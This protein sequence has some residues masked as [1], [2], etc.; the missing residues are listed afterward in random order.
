M[1]P[2]VSADTPFISL[3]SL[4]QACRRSMS[5]LTS[6]CDTQTKRRRRRRRRVAVTMVRLCGTQVGPRC[7]S[8][9]A[10]DESLFVLSVPYEAPRERCLNLTSTY[11]LRQLAHAFGGVGPFES[12]TLCAG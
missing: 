10:G 8:S 5:G 4:L 9:V 2:S 3:A 12:H 11:Y 6:G 1:P 7:G